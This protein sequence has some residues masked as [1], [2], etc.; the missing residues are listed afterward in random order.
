M[1]RGYFWNREKWELVGAEESSLPE[2][3]FV[4][5]PLL[6]V[7][8]VVAIMGVA[9]ALFLPFMGFATAAQAIARKLFPARMRRRAPQG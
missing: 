7:F 5:V 3:K 6:L 9:F 8:A 1:R 2:G 4:R